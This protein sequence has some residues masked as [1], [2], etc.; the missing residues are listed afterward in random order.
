MTENVVS[1]GVRSVGNGTDFPGEA[2]EASTIQVQRLVDP[3]PL[4]PAWDSSITAMQ[5]DG[6]VKVRHKACTSSDPTSLSSVQPKGLSTAVS[7]SEPG[8][9][10]LTNGSLD[11]QKASNKFFD[12]TYIFI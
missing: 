3:H 2:S 12:L 10:S 1:T 5:L 6:R 8:D 7:N 4:M 11:V 9:L